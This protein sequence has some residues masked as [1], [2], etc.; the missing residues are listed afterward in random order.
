M[1][2]TQAPACQ[3][4][5]WVS[6]LSF[7]SWNAIRTM[8]FGAAVLFAASAPASAQRVLGIDVSAWQ[9]NLSNA[10]WATL[11]RPTNQQVSGIYGDG[12]DFVFIRA[13]RGGTTGEDHRSGGYPPTDNTFTNLSQRYDDPYFVQNITRATAAG[14]LAGSYH[15]ARPDII[16]TTGNS[17]GIPN[18]GTD[19]ANHF[20]EMA[21]AWMRPGYLLP[22]LDLEA[23]QSQRTSAQLSTFAVEFSD[24]IYQVTGIRPMIYVS[25]NYA[26]YVNSTV[27]VA[28][29]NLWIARWPNQNDPDSIDVQNIH[30][31]PSPSTANVY[32]KWNPNFTVANPY[33][34]GHP[35]IFWQYASTARLNGYASNGANIDV[36]VAQGGM[37]FIKDYYVPALWMNNSDGQWTTLSNWNSGLPPVPPV[38]APGQLARVGSLTLPSERVPGSQDTV[39]L[40]R[41]NANITV[42]LGSGIHNIRKLYVREALNITGGSLTINYIPSPDSTPFAAQFSGAV[43]LGGTGNLTVHTLQVDPTRMFM[44]G[45]GTLAFNTINLMPHSASPAKIVL[46]GNVSINPLAGATAT[47]ARGPGTGAFGSIDLGGGSRSFSVGNGTDEVDLSADVPIANGALTKTGPGT[48]RL[49]NGNG[50]A[51]GTTVS[52]GRLLVN[53]TLGSGTGSGAVTVNAGT[54]GGTG[55]IA[56]PVAVLAGGTV[57]PGTS[58]GVLTINNS[59]TLSGSTIV[60]LNA[61]T[62]TND[63]IR[64]LTSVTYGGTLILSNLSGTIGA[65]HAFKLF[66][67]NSYQ[68][69]F[70][71]LTPATPGPSLAWNTNTLAI[72]GTL[73]VLSTAPTTLLA[74]HATPGAPLTLSWPA[75][76]TGWRLQ[77]QTNSIAVGLSTN[78]VDVSNSVLTNQITVTIDPNIDCAFYRLIFP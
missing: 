47:I 27:P 39:V 12:R 33:P 53:N 46:S 10:N 50:Y 30:P 25:Q 31:P 34:D 67:A 26:N 19:E 23:G 69:A 49:N 2:L 21:G 5:A 11:H 64:G 1:T 76:H 40:D 3:T 15:F 51:G 38:Q 65:T 16:A 8:L 7:R 60:E 29:P 74:M 78:W 59:L 41:P 66:N 20:I 42:T 70:A 28:I 18:H 75:D 44:V 55:T 56:G 22:V 9:G 73:R 52:A 4:P 24:R 14:M 77:I 54:L 57:S 32:G 62:G 71:A 35:W 58:I 72:D 36:D 43:T 6:L 37:E 13:S 68:G 48:M 17:G 63:L 61:A 45:G